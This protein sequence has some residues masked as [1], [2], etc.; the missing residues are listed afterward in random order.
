MRYCVDMQTTQ[1]N[2]RS[3]MNANKM[4]FIVSA[5]I[6]AASFSASANTDCEM[7]TDRAA[8]IRGF[9][10]YQSRY[11][12][13]KKEMDEH[14]DR[15]WGEYYEYKEKC[16][17]WKKT[18]EGIAAFAAKEGKIQQCLKRNALKEEGTFRIGMSKADNLLCGYGKPEKINRTV[19]QKVTHEQWVYEDGTYVYFRNGV[20]YAWQD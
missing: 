17:A 3:D 4:R 16:E 8:I 9:S 20:L 12:S 11:Y 6:I 5:L 7:A 1:V 2:K 14:R 19:T 13:S 10:D 18:P 15:I